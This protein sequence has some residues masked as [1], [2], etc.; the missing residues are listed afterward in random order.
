[1]S[2][3]IELKS[4]KYRIW[5]TVVSKWVTPWLNRKECLKVIRA[6]KQETLESQM[7]EE[8]KYFPT[9]WFNKIGKVHR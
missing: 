9:G 3:R 1:M 5:S 4:G 7:E 2:W 6:S 8:E